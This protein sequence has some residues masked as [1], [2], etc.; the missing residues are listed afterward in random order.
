MDLTTPEGCIAETLYRWHVGSL[1]QCE[2]LAERALTGL[3][4]LGFTVTKGEI[5]ARLVVC[6]DCNAV[7]WQPP[8]DYFAYDYIRC[9]CPVGSEPE[10]E[11]VDIPGSTLVEKSE[12][13][14]ADSLELKL[15]RTIE[16]ELKRYPHYVNVISVSDMATDLIP[17]LLPL[18]EE[19]S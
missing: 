2:L 8:V 1:A 14:P 4:G 3:A 18:F 7:W 9:H 16:E 19:R 6:L 12:V 5:S 17:V 13:P 15:R 11:F 10:F